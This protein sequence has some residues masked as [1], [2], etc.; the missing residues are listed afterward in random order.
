MA[1]VLVVDDERSIREFLEILLKRGGHKVRLAEDATGGI[2]RLKEA[3]ADLV[4]TDLRLPRGSGMDVLSHVA[5]HHPDTE[6]IMM[7]AF[8]TTENAVEAMKLG[9][10]DYIIK[11]FKVDELQV[12]VDRA[13]HHRTLTQE[14]QQLKQTLDARQ[15]QH[16]LLGSST[17]MKQVFELIGKVAG[18]RTNVLL[19]G[20]SGTGKELVARAI[21]NRGPRHDDPFVPINCGAI[22]ESLI[23]SELF[24]H[25]K[26]SFTGADSDKLGLFEIAGKGTVFLDE[27]GDLPLPMQVRLLRVLQERKL[28]R[29]GGQED[30]DLHCRIIAATNRNLEQDVKGGR[31]REDLYFRL[32]VIQIELP[33]LRDRRADIPALAEAFVAKFT[34]QQASDVTRIA[35]DAMVALSG[36]AWPGNVR[37]LENA[38]ERG[39]T[40]APGDVL[41]K[42][43]LPM[44]ILDS[45]AEGRPVVDVP[46]LAIEIPDEGIDL[47]AVLE[48]IERDLLERALA[49]T[50]GKKKKAADLV[51]LSFR[52]FRYRVAKLGITAGDDE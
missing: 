1:D 9:A 23:E 18:A 19:T 3:P 36:Y 35:D 6:V 5:Q 10:Y 26:G 24:G 52:S 8:A 28:K 17:A 47:E 34:E 15:A 32:N 11:P 49:R 51:G 29:V 43:E 39:V 4:L 37:E 22:P 48:G 38:I 14:N 45:Q 31:F 27:I 33:P 41:T 30:I 46:S 44:S 25:M 7:T 50:G 12:V 42:A 2:A 21:H 16:R 20:E 40:L 13:L